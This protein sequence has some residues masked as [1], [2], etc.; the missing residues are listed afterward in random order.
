MR[1]DFILRPAVELYSASAAL[2]AAVWCVAAPQTLL[3][4]PYSGW[5]LALALLALSALR[6]RQGV[7]I[8]R[9]RRRV[10]HLSLWTL[11]ASRI[12]Q[13]PDSLFL[14][15]GFRWLPT[16]TQRLYL[17]HLPQCEHW[18]RTDRPSVSGGDPLLH[19]VELHEG[20]VTLPL[21]DR[22]GHTLVL[23]TTRVG[24]TRLAE[25]LIT[26]DIRR[27]DTVIVFD[28]KGD[29]DLLRRV[30][31]EAHRA[32]RES[33]FWLFHLGWPEISARYNAVGRF[34]R[35]SEVA[36]RIAG[37]LS[38]EGNSAAFR[39]FAWRFVNIIT[40][41]LVAL[42]QRPDYARIARHVINIDE[43]FIDYARVFLPGYDRQAWDNVVRIAGGITE[44][45]TPRNLQ[46]RD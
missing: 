45:N 43:L 16:H 33:V 41:A 28:P 20:R 6:L 5:L 9:F 19:G 46:G 23:G 42:G 10:R 25:L 44:K 37:Q 36:S 40:R 8:L 7:R 13:L 30:W 14:G 39:E 17:C 22:P 12:P 27:G 15:R 1:L 35:I 18:L 38:T 31:A 26:Q 34:G 3:L 29:A 2:L 4:T 21:R 32:G 11:S 24:K